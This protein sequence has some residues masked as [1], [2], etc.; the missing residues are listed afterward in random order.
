MTEQRTIAFSKMSGLGN[1][2][3]I[4]DARENKLEPPLTPVQV[5]QLAA[6]DNEITK[7]CD[8]VLVLHPPKSGGDIFMQIFNADG[9]EVEACGNG[10][11]AI[12]QWLVERGDLQKVTIETL[13][14][15]L[16]CHLI[17][18]F[19]AQ[20]PHYM[21][22]AM[23]PPKFGWRDIP[24]NKEIE[25][26]TQVQLHEDLPPAFLVNVGNPHAV[27][28]VADSDNVDDMTAQYGETLVHHSLFAQGANI[29]FAFVE[30][31]NIQSISLATWERGAGLTQACGTGACAVAI[32]ATHLNLRTL[33]GVTNVYPPFARQDRALP[34][35][36]SFISVHYNPAHK[37][38][39]QYG[40]A[41]LEFD[42]EITL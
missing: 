11:R 33:K 26:T 31:N 9:G 32:A 13:G 16:N 38:L 14:G 1:D 30:N 37:T 17:K 22:V 34:I 7:G 10:A 15:I 42:G 4:I 27:F 24:L 36:L 21:A 20:D 41:A 12:T 6:R 28:F 39:F 18:N 5:W 8:Q 2:F 25:D 23:P 40:P 19:D 35:F 3:I 29:N